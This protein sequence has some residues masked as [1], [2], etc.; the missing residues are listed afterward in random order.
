MQIKDIAPKIIEME[1]VPIYFNDSK[2]FSAVTYLK[3]N[4]D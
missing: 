1:K 4:S 3:P 2:A